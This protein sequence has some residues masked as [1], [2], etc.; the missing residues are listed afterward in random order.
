[1]SEENKLLVRRYLEIYN[2]GNLGE[3]AGTISPEY[4]HTITDGRTGR[5]VDL[6]K[7]RITDWRNSFP[8]TN[9]TIEEAIT[10]GDKVVT[11]YTVQATQKGEFDGIPPTNTQ[12]TF[13]AVDIHRIAGG[14]IVEGW[15]KWDRLGLREQLGVA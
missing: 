7:Q 3:V 8:D 5:G 6:V 15:R 12:V 10:E 11:R 1:M 4:S 9:I 2:S 13:E 14:K